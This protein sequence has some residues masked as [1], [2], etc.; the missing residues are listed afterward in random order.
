MFGGRKKRK[1]RNSWMYEVTNRMREKEINNIKWM[2]K[3]EWR[4]KIKLR[5]RKM[6]K[7]WYFVHKYLKPKCSDGINLGI[8]VGF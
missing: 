4:R 1:P 2:N 5:H 8:Y 6:W 3:E 7:H